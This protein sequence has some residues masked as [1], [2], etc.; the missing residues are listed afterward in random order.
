MSAGLESF[1]AFMAEL[2]QL[3]KRNRSQ[4]ETILSLMQENLNLKAQ[5]KVEHG[6]GLLNMTRNKELEKELRALRNPA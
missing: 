5:I 4:E 6:I 1:N 2:T 3:S